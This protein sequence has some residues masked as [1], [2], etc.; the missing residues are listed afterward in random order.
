METTCNQIQKICGTAGWYV[1]SVVITYDD[2]TTESFGKPGYH[3][4]QT[5]LS[6]VVT[7]GQ[8]MSEQCLTFTTASKEHIDK[9]EFHNGCG[10]L[11]CW[12]RITT[13]L[14]NTLFLGQLN[15]VKTGITAW[16]L[17]SNKT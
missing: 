11:A 13:N 15:K 10:Y 9:V 6:Q 8:A 4:D 14:G 1:N 16:G 7:E 2:A 5:G 3:W 12:I 17:P